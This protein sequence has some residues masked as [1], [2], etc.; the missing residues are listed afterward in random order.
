MSS[1]ET[2]IPPNEPG[3]NIIIDDDDEEFS[4]YDD[5]VFDSITDTDDDFDQALWSIINICYVFPHMCCYIC[6]NIIL[7]IFIGQNIHET[8]LHDGT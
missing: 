7:P 3:N 2:E 8:L 6:C 1:A 5:D 4:D